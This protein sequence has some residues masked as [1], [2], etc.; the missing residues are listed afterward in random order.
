MRL[1]DDDLFFEELESDFED[2]ISARNLSDDEI[3]E[4]RAFLDSVF[5][6]DCNCMS[7]SN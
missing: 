3:R 5:N 4:E 2:Y 7:D 6:H 1:S